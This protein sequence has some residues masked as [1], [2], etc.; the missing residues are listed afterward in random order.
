V[1]GNKRAAFDVTDTFLR[2][3]DFR[4]TA[5]LA[6]AYAF[7]MERYDTQTFRF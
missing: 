2:L 5:K 3:N 7:I 4:I 6:K 1:E